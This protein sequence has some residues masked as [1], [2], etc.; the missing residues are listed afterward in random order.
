MIVK[1]SQTVS[2]SIVEE[3]VMLVRRRR[4]NSPP[5]I[6]VEDVEEISLLGL[7]ERNVGAKRDGAEA[8]EVAEPEVIKPEGAPQEVP[9]TPT[10]AAQL[11]A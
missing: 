11:L 9:L 1:T 8:V 4:R 6:E 2:S 10:V 7:S 5:I 3:L